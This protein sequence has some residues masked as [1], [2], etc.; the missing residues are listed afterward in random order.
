MN[1]FVTSTSSYDELM[2]ILLL[3]HCMMPLVND[4][5]DLVQKKKHDM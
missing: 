2:E 3:I 5:L 1:Q 4:S